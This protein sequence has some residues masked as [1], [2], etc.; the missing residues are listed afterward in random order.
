MKALDRGSQLLRIRNLSHHLEVARLVEHALEHFPEKARIIG[1]N[2]TLCGTHNQ[3]I[4]FLPS[5]YD[6][7]QG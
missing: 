5:H 3:A 7:L 4:L 1:Q 6:V 2:Y